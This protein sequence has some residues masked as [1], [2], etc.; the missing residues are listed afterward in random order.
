MRQSSSN[1]SLK[2]T[3]F[4][5][6]T[7]ERDSLHPVDIASTFPHP[8]LQGAMSTSNIPS[9][10]PARCYVHFQHSHIPYCKVLCPPPTF[11]HPIL[12]GAMS[13]S[14]I[15]TSHTARCYV[16]LQHSH[17]PSCKVPCLPPTFQLIAVTERNSL[18]PTD[19]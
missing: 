18:H 3:I 2:E 19:C 4:I 8:I 1:C 16:H 9:P 6:L 15:P 11:P 5:Q 17:T 7:A 14:N 12:Q 13:T 10:Y